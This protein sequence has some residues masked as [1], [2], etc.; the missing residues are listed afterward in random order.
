MSFITKGVMEGFTNT[1]TTT[2]YKW[3]SPVQNM[4][5]SS[6]KPLRT[7]SATINKK[8]GNY[9]VRYG[10]R[11]KQT[12][13]DACRDMPKCTA[14]VRVSKKGSKGPSCSFYNGSGGQ[15]KANGYRLMYAMPSTTRK[16][17]KPPS[18]K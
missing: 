17:I 8:D 12:C 10:S 14:F 6:R 15:T 4:K 3:A 2:T 11:K 7:L 16:V 1:T 5:I 13:K 9:M 18:S